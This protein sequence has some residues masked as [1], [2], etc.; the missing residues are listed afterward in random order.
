MFMSSLWCDCCYVV[1]VSVFCV[2]SNVVFTQVYIYMCNCMR[3]TGSSPISQRRFI[4][5]SLPVSVCAFSGDV[6][7]PWC[8]HNLC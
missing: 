6:F 7:Y 8:R 1:F 2:I 5:Y 3:R 4:P